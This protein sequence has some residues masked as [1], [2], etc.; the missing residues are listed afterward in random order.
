MAAVANTSSAPPTAVA[1][2]AAATASPPWAQI[3]RGPEPEPEPEPKP[4]VTPPPASVVVVAGNSPDNGES[5]AVASQKSSA[6]NKKPMSKPTPMNG[7]AAE[8]SGV[9]VVMGADVWPSLSEC[10]KVTGVDTPS[11]P[12]GQSSVRSLSSFSQ[13]QTASN[14]SNHHM[15][16]NN[17]R[18]S[19][20][21]FTKREVGSN[22][23]AN[24]VPSHQLTGEGSHYHPNHGSAKPNTGSSLEN[25]GRDNVQ[26]HTH[27]ESGQR[28]S[29][30]EHYH[31]RNTF[32]KG[33]GGPHSRGDGSHQNYGGRRSD[34]ERGNPDFNHQRSFNGR[35][36]PMHHPRGFPRGYVRPS[37][38]IAPPMIYPTAPPFAN[39]MLP[40]VFP[41][42]IVAPYPPAFFYSAPAPDL[43]PKL[44]VQVNYY[45]SND[46]L[47]K[48]THLRSLMDENGWIHVD[49][50]VQFPKVQFLTNDAN[51]LLEAVRPSTIVEVQGDKIRRRG[52]WKRWLLPHNVWFPSA[53]E[54]PS[55]NHPAVS[56]VTDGIQSVS[57]DEK[58]NCTSTAEVLGDGSASVSQALSGDSE[59]I[60][61][62]VVGEENTGGC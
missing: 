38:P 18:S 27:R 48:D 31:H 11:T 33:N 39:T 53:S 15:T 6:W 22:S 21:R 51:H 50:I 44:L 26:N 34:Q 4:E 7:E 42:P 32:R 45:F 1:T 5:N 43:Y 23:I 46:N 3:V 47:V 56:A 9:A 13:K 36:A 57:V 8:S 25:S 17:A 24:G 60:A 28:N 54:S 40:V 2:V 16:N 10:T 58:T 37:P 59:S 61:K 41:V 62:V 14:N 52:D 19:R 55:S 12:T 30:G 20:Q 35:D 29:S 49:K